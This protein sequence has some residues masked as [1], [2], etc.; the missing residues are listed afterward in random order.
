MIKAV[1]FDCG[2]VVVYPRG[3]YWPVPVDIERILGRK[4][5]FDLE[6]AAAALNKY[7]YIIDEG[8]L[9]T[10]LNHEYALRRAF[11]ECMN[12]DLGLDMS[13]GQISET[14]RSLTYNDSR[15]ALYDDARQ[16]LELFK[17]RFV[18]GFVSNAMPSMVRALMNSGVTDGLDCFIVSCLVACQKPDEG[19]YLQALKEI[20][21]KPD[22]CVFVDDLKD[23]LLT[24]A[25]LGM[26]VIRMARPFYY[27]TPVKDF[28]WHGAT[29]R[30]LS[31]VYSLVT[32]CE[33]GEIQ[34]GACA[35]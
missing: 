29:A 19:I 31:E 10:G 13:D 21:L 3:G 28:E 8:Q 25:K 9:I 14:A 20:K 22:E 1:L 30:D 23:N 26:R 32:A 27:A 7:S 2:G 11:T 34:L 4:L 16:G 24:A 33:A 12:R 15:Y 35:E 17:G 18:T 5:E 6:K